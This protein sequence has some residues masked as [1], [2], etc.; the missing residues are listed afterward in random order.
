MEAILKNQ[1]RHV[2]LA[3][4][5]TWS[6]VKSSAKQQNTLKTQIKHSTVQLT[7]TLVS[8]YGPPS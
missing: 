1:F 4:S 8:V 2:S 5:G 3:V 6:G 7:T